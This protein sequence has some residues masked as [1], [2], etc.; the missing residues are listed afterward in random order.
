MTQVSRRA[1]NSKTQDRIL[2]LF[3][4]SIV[5]CKNPSDASLFIEDL[6][7]PTEKV[8]LSKRFSIAYMLHQGYS[9]D[10]IQDILKVSRTTVGHTALWL[11]RSGKGLIGMIGKIKRNEMTKK[12][13]DDIEE[14]FLDI[15]AHSKGVD[16]RRAQSDLWKFRR[17]KRKE[18]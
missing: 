5:L 15:I 9:Y 2:S 18:F 12:I 8:M 1:I 11:K 13:L 16:W 6:L 3:L 4:T 10:N 17:E 14:G 7:T